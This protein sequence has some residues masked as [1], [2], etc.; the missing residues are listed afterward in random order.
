MTLKRNVFTGEQGLKPFVPAVLSAREIEK[1]LGK[2]KA[3][4]T[5]RSKDEKQCIG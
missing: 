2:E 1:L 4:D 5:E 3:M